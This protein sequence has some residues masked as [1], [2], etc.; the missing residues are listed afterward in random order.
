MRTLSWPSDSFGVPPGT[1]VINTIA[2]HSSLKMRKIKDRRNVSAT[3]NVNNNAN[4]Y[5]GYNINNNNNTTSNNNNN[6]TE[7]DNISIATFPDN[8]LLYWRSYSSNSSTTTTANNN[9][10]N[11][12]DDS[13]SN[14]NNNKNIANGDGRKLF[15]ATYSFHDFG[16]IN[17]NNNH[18]NNNSNNSNNNNKFIRSSSR[19]SFKKFF[20]SISTPIGKRKSKNKHSYTLD[21]SESINNNNNDDVIK[22]DDINNN[23]IN[24]NI[25]YEY[26]LN[27]NTATEEALMTLPGVSRQTAQN[28]VKYRIMMGGFKNIQDIAPVSGVG[29]DNFKNFRCEITCHDPFPDVV[30]DNNFNKIINN[31]NTNNN[32]F[33]KINISNNNIKNTTDNNNIILTT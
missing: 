29:A 10:N 3:F 16:N 4:T 15:H 24:N 30:I 25:N 22:K 9:N 28:I 26:L 2:E 5:N 31:D 1:P 6:H 11:N 21:S 12:S 19:N 13:S 14:N 33:N 7:L 32:N 23:N 27:I 18:V 17:K 20:S 8:Q